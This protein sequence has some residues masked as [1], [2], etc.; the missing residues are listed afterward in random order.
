MA[1][2]LP[3]SGGAANVTKSDCHKTF[4]V[5]KGFTENIPL[6]TP[7]HN[8]KTLDDPETLITTTCLKKCGRR[9]SREGRCVSP[10][11]PI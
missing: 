1:D 11:D 8:I 10:Q 7:N 3:V 6:L 9:L 5:A 2:L 4:I